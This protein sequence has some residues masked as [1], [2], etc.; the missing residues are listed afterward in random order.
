MVARDFCRLRQNVV[1]FFFYVSEKFRAFRFKK[2][3]EWEGGY[4]LGVDPT[5]EILI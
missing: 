1:A 3:G 5:H 2:S 4:P